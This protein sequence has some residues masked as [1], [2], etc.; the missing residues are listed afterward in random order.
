MEEPERALREFRRVL[1]TGGVLVVPTFLHGADPA[2]RLLSRARSLVS[3]FVARPRFDLAG[4]QAL[5]ESAGFVVERAQQLPGLF[6]V[7]YIVCRSVKS[8]DVDES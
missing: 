6:P 5:V 3:P 1:A 8:G 2:R 7:G 4:L